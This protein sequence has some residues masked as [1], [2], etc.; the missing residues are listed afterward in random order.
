MFRFVF[1]F[2]LRAVTCASVAALAGS[3]RG[4]PDEGRSSA[5]I[6]ENGESA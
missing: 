3:S 6:G 4:C 1:G 5:L 2:R